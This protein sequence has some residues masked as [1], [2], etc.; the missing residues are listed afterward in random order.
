MQ[1]VCNLSTRLGNAPQTPGLPLALPASW[2][3]T[4][5][6]RIPA[7]RA[8]I[9]QSSQ[10]DVPDPRRPGFFQNNEFPSVF[11]GKGAAAASGGPECQTFPL[12]AGATWS[13]SLTS[14]E[15]F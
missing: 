7:R 3:L 11:S 6:E 2:I 10:P 4:T 5:H 15:R 1:F 9:D 14:A 8:C 13:S 12:A